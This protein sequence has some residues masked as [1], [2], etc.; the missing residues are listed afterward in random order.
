MVKYNHRTIPKENNFAYI[1][2]Q[3]LNLGVRSMGWILDMRRFKIYLKEKYDVSKTYIFIGFVAENQRMYNAFQEYVYTLVDY[4]YSKEKLKNVISP[5]SKTC[6]S[7]LK[8]TAKEKLMFLD[9]LKEKLEYKRK[10]T[11]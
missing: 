2:G 6:S 8:K 10:S 9:N 4:F 1:D 5:C 7:L 3:N 11:A